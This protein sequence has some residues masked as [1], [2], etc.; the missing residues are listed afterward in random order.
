RDAYLLKAQIQ[1]KQS[2]WED[3]VASLRQAV[4]LDPT[5]NYLRVY[6]G[7][8]YEKSGN[9]EN[10]NQIYNIIRNQFAD[11]DEVIKKIRASFVQSEIVP[12]ISVEEV[13]ATSVAPI[14]ER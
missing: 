4:I 10:A 14:P 6:L 12:Q 2:Q 5:N 3:V 13:S 9:H 11:G 7:V 8:A 1:I